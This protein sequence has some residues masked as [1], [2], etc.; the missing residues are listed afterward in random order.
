MVAASKRKGPAVAANLVKAELLHMRAVRATEQTH[1]DYRDDGVL[2]R[3]L[4]R[5]LREHRGNANVDL[6]QWSLRVRSTRG[7][8][9]LA[10]LN[11]TKGGENDI[12][13]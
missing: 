7:S 4:E 6:A 8:T 10:I 2:R 3:T 11:I 12:K 9:V 1:L 13:R 5:M